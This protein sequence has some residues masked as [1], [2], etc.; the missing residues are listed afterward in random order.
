MTQRSPEDFAAAF[1][2]L[3]RRSAFR[4]ELLDRYVAANE[5]EPFGRFRAGLP[6][7]PSW[8]EPWKRL[9][10]AA[11]RD[12]KVMARV[13]VVD[14]PL[15]DYLRFELTCAYPANVAAGEDVRILA[16]TTWP[17]LDLP[18]HDYW[19]FDDSDVA[20]MS[21]DGLG[22]WLDV[23]MISEPPEVTTYCQARDLA[24]RRSVALTDYLASTGLK[25]AI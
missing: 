2:A 24:V 16:R 23:T 18:D 8:R 9:V 10:Q 4:L 17:D 25:E 15:S 19:L 20:V 1:P 14:V 11:V 7:V 22:N 13:H 12:G 6:Q 3:F 5:Q 21:Y